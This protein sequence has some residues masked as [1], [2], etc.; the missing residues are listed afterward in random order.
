MY[1][2]VMHFLGIG[3]N[4]DA[5]LG[6]WY[7]RQK[8]KLTGFNNISENRTLLSRFVENFMYDIMV[9]RNNLGWEIF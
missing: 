8:L 2:R 6:A 7:L 4:S 1:W 5:K 3:D 9:S